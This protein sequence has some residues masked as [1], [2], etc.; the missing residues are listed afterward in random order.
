MKLVP[1]ENISKTTVRITQIRNFCVDP[2]CII[3][4]HPA[5]VMH[6]AVSP[7]IPG[8]LRVVEGAVEA[9]QAP[10]EIR[11]EEEPT[12]PATT[13]SEIEPIST[14]V[15]EAA[16]ETTVVPDEPTVVEEAV[17]QPIEEA[18]EQPIEETTAVEEAVE[19]VKES[20][21]SAESLRGIYLEAPGVTET[22]VDLI[23]NAFPTVADLANASKE[24]L[25]ELGVSKNQAKR[26]VTWAKT[27]QGTLPESDESNL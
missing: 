16:V 2:G 26:A 15:V 3:K 21:P 25:V 24:D 20:E 22:N 14:P 11:S 18:V 12:A 6:P 7:Y 9:V 4:V 23:L 1:L 8:T 27:Q 13:I 5:T 19:P 10:S 17:Q